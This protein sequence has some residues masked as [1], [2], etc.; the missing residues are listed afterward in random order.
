MTA[1]SNN[2]A[3]ALFMLA[4][5]EN[6]VDVFYTDLKT[7]KDAFTETPEYTELLSAPSIAKA[8][9]LSSIETVFG[10]KICAHILSFLQ[11]LCEKGKTAELSLV[12]EEYEKLRDAISKTAEAVV[13]SA[14]EL[15]DAQQKT[16][17][18]ALEKRIGKKVTLKTVIDKSVLGGLIV[19]LDGEVIDGSVK[20]GLK[21]IREVIGSE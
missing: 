4:T 15:S 3:E 2:F 5:E 1:T 19:T 6:A 7:A 17:I 11:L 9:R 18:S 12:F 8:D 10:G 16:L 14:V 20:T 21:H 13:T